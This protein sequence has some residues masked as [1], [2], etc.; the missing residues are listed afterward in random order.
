[1]KKQPGIDQVTALKHADSK[2]T[3]TG[4]NNKTIAFIYGI[5]AYTYFEICKHLR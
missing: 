1:M 3:V 2:Q 4:R 5:F